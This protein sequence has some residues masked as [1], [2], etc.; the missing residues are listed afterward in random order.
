M[1]YSPKIFQQIFSRRLFFVA[2]VKAI[3]FCIL[4]VRIWW[5][6]IKES[7]KY[8]DMA[9]GN[10]I[11]VRFIL[12]ARGRIL[13]DD[14]FPI[15]DVKPK[16]DIVLIPYRVKNV[17]PVLEK[18]SKITEIPPEKIEEI[19]KMNRHL[20]RYAFISIKS[21][22]NWDEAI[23]VS[24]RL[25]ELV[26]IDIQII[27]ERYYPNHELFC[28][29]SGYVGTVTKQEQEKDN[30]SILRIPGMRIGKQGIERTHDKELRGKAG[31]MRVEVNHTGKVN[32]ELDRK[33]PVSGKDLHLTI[34]SEIQEAAF[35]AMKGQT[36]SV[37]VINVNNGA[38]LSMY[39]SP[40][41]NPNLFTNGIS[42]K[43][44]EAIRT[45]IQAPM[46]N[47]A[48][49]GQYPPGS[50]FKMISLIAGLEAGVIK[51]EDT[52]YCNGHTKLGNSKF[53]CWKYSGHGHVNAVG[54]LMH[55]CD[56]YFYELS[57]RVGIKK[58]AEVARRYGLGSMTGIDLPFEKSGTVPDEAWKM[59]H[60]GKA[61][62]KG[63]TLISSI[64]QGSVLTTPLQLAVMTARLATDKMVTPHLVRQ[65]NAPEF[66][67]MEGVIPEV[68]QI[69]R[70]GMFNVVN[71]IGGTAQSA[72]IPA[73][74]GR[75]AGKTGTA[76]VRRI[77]A[78][79]RKRGVLKNDQLEWKYRDHGLFVSFAPY[80]N[81]MFAVACV[82]EHGGSGSGVAAP[83]ATKALTKTFEV[84]GLNQNAPYEG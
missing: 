18:L 61:W 80:D 7:Q 32:H 51:P 53:H 67:M 54:S 82:A 70:K 58:I 12:P 15:A 13:T 78:A 63:E 19:Q 62:L 1:K 76:Q 59:E 9:E 21:L 29:V 47:K 25:H 40:A 75:A 41:F 17:T 42:F 83:I 16:F 2:G 31:A 11:D 6:Q 36:G 69:A 84:Y 79:E 55:S 20:Y 37:V 60:Y 27:S 49:I 66:E 33:D 71:V 39:S 50:T 57:Q 5:L 46:N 81:P 65:E 14:L 68:T 8:F 26:G 45:N 73:E 74:Y 52:I 22:S 77:T 23:K 72:K 28:H 24:D 64:G 4:G 38:I 48:I 56:V 44:W 30:A 3:L 34:H 35:E 10:R 43:D